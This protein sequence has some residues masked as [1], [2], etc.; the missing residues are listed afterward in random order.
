M[1]NHILN[2]EQPDTPAI[3]IQR[4]GRAR[5]ASSK[6]KTVFVHDMI[7]DNSKDI[8]KLENLN[9]IMG[10][11]DGGVSVNQAQSESLKQIMEKY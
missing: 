9:K 10:L 3:K 1:A 6:Y 7:T 8:E 4:T 5:R 11:V 2:Y